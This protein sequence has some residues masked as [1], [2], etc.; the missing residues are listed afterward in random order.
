MSPAAQDRAKARLRQ[1][2]ARMKKDGLVDK[3]KKRGG[4]WALAVTYAQ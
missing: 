3:S 1:T 2:L 4:P